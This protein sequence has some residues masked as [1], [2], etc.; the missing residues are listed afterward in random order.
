MAAKNG[1]IRDYAWAIGIAVVAALLI[2][3]FVIE[4]YRI[5]TEAMKPTLQPGD[6]IFVA[7]W[8]FGIRRRAP[9][10]GEVV[11][12]SDRASA[13]DYLRRIVG[14]PGDLI[15]LKKGRLLVNGAPAEVKIDSELGTDCGVETLPGGKS[16]GLCWNS[17]A[18]PETKAPQRVPPDSV[19]AI[20]D[21]RSD[22][23]TAPSWGI[24]PIS[25]IKGSAL[26]IWLSIEPGKPAGTGPRLRKAR[27]FRRI[28]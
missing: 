20:S 16:H 2:R 24:F 15:E 23:G 8:P 5:P 17:A 10:R 22:A 3:A 11:L 7:K 18:L 14:L 26:W 19:F 12:I 4:A 25:V 27:M 13:R 6:T 28:E 1:A 9:V 21:L